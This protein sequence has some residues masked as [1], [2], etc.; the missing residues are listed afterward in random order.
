MNLITNRRINN[1]KITKDLGRLLS[2]NY[3]G[4]PLPQY[5]G[6]SILSKIIDYL[7][8][9]IPPEFKIK[10]IKK[11][12][13]QIQENKEAL[14]FEK[15][16]QVLV[17]YDLLLLK[18]DPQGI[19]EMSIFSKLIQ[20]IATEVLKSKEYFYNKIMLEDENGKPVEI[21]FYHNMSLDLNT[22][23]SVVSNLKI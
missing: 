9:V 20:E 3:I 13:R 6:E 23:F 12:F 21:E 2:I 4:L 5:N 10:E 11:L 7:F 15:K 16:E 8:L 19:K 22:D 17:I 1:S 18:S 14:S